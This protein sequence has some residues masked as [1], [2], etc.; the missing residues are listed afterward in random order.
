MGS[1]DIPLNKT[2][3]FQAIKAAHILKKKN[4]KHITTS[5]LMRARQTAKIVA[6]LLNIQL[7]IIDELSQMSLGEYEGKAV[8]DVVVRKRWL[9]GPLN[10]GE[11]KREDFE[12]R[13]IDGFNE[14][15]KFSEPTLIIAHGGV[16][17][18]IQRILGWPKV[19]LT[20]GVPI[21]HRPSTHPGHQWFICAVD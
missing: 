12:K 9:D 2:G 10:A 17:C 16:Y 1:Q 20:N 15:L 7:T 4:I 13:V 18:T 5:P 11:E 3:E 6:N 19:D 8:D 14:A 21:F